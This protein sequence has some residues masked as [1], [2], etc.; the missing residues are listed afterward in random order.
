MTALTHRKSVD[1]Q[2]KPGWVVVEEWEGLSVGDPVRV[3][4]AS[5]Q[6]RFQSHTTT[7]AGETW[8]TVYGGLKGHGTTRSFRPERVRAR[9][10]RRTG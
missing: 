8:I 9:G 5:G 3:I 6:F 2:P 4:G 7:A 1:L 10:R